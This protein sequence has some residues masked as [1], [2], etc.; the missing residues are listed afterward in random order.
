MNISIDV[1]QTDGMELLI[2]ANV[3]SLGDEATEYDNVVED[4]IPLRERSNI[5]VFG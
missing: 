5:A 1:K 4:T 3:S 2:K